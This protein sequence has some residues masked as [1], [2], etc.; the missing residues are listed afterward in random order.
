MTLLSIKKHTYK[1]QHYETNSIS[2][3][4]NKITSTNTTND[5]YCL[6]CFKSY[7]TEN[8]LEELE[9]ICDNNEYCQMIMPDQ[10]K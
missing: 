4:F 1:Y 6:N 7:T 8:K 2:K 3:L 10:K 9:L 5:C